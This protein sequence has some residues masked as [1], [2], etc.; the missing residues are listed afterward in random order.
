MKFDLSRFK[1]VASDKHST[2]LKHDD[3]HT[4]KLA[5]APL[6]PKM[7]GELHALPMANGGEV[8]YDSNGNH[9]ESKADHNLQIV[10]QQT[11]ESNQANAKRL[12]YADGG[13]AESKQHLNKD[14]YGNYIESSEP[15]APQQPMGVVPNQ[16]GPAQNKEAEAYA[17]GER[18]NYAEG[19][20]ADSSKGPVVINIGGNGQMPQIPES[21]ANPN[22]G[23]QAINSSSSNPKPISQDPVKQAY[24]HP[25]DLP[26]GVK[27]EDVQQ[28]AQQAPQSQSQPIIDPQAGNSMS[29]GQNAS[30]GAPNASNGMS[31]QP[32]PPAPEKPDPF[33]N[34]AGSEAYTQGLSS[35]LGGQAQEAAAQGQLGQAE[36][37][38]AGQQAAADR[39]I[40]NTFQANMANV[41]PKLN[42]AIEAYKMGHINPT[43]YQ[44]NQSV[45]SK[46][47]TAIGII[48]AGFGGS[49]NVQR[50]VDNV[51]RQIDRDVNAQMANQQTKQNV[52]TGY[53][54]QMGNARDAATMASALNA[55]IYADQFKQAA[56]QSKDPLAQARLLQASGQLVQGAADKL[57]QYS[58]LKTLQQGANSGIIP[59]ERLIQFSPLIPANQKLPALTQLKQ[60]QDAVGLRDHTLSAFDQM[61]KIN[62]V[63]GKFAN[64]IQARK[65]IAALRDSTLDKLTRDTSGR[66]TPETVKLIGGTFDTFLANPE[67]MAIQRQMVNNLLSQDMNYP[68]IK[69]A[70]IDVNNLG[71]YDINGQPRIKVSPPVRR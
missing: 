5:H 70:G 33:G 24:A 71:R 14:K 10:N 1:K 67:T 44:E 41:M 53:L 11:P 60:A 63:G 25:G 31:T 54:H 30:G 38:I 43:H 45:G 2:T 32:T 69:S 9:I 49:E 6:S 16:R 37:K 56:A 4:I 36:A 26:Y 12:A 20:E 22:P 48:G 27:P 58:M 39:A 13:P 35:Q 55:N 23:S 51:N 40:S 29:Q 50:A 59:P 21:M 68:L 57:G 34:V 15:E 28:M 62:T 65:Q 47:G 61:A 7:R 52:F 19:G 18:K 66:V 3:G 8:K 46:I 17:T 42:D 64:P